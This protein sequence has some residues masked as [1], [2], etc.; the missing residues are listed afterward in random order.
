MCLDAPSAPQLGV[1]RHR[2]RVRS[3]SAQGSRYGQTFSR[4]YRD[5]QQRKS[6]DSVSREDSGRP[7][8]RFFLTWQPRSQRA[9]EH[10]QRSNP[11]LPLHRGRKIAR[12]EL[13]EVAPVWHCY[14]VL[15][16]LEVKIQN[17]V[18]RPTVKLAQNLGE[19]EAGCDGADEGGADGL[20]SE[21]CHSAAIELTALK[22]VLVTSLHC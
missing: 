22:Q 10:P 12:I 1:F 9:T 16:G 7:S 5:G 14:A 2:C 3:R 13:A 4:L 8:G 15:D 11:E 19:R 21:K 17:L 18:E 20:P 6:S